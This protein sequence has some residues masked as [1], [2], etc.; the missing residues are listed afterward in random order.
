MMVSEVVADNWYIT[1][2]PRTL[3]IDMQTVFDTE[4]EAIAY[5]TEQGFQN[6]SYESFE[7]IS[8][9]GQ[10]QGATL[11]YDAPCCDEEWQV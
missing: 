1:F 9:G 3:H 5:L 8:S 7:R 11:W 2:Y 4:E 10:E 6:R